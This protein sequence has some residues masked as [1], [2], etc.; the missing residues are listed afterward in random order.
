MAALHTSNKQYSP[1]HSHVRAHKQTKHSNACLC[2]LLQ[3]GTRACIHTHLSACKLPVC[4]SDAR[5]HVQVSP[6]LV[7]FRESVMCPSEAADAS[8]GG[9]TAFAAAAARTAATRVVEAATP[10]GVLLVRV[11]AWPA[12]PLQASC[13]ICACFWREGA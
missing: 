1:L 2:T 12:R 3:T 8:A 4:T 6:P 10:N 9:H 5:V 13:A 7:A 11:R